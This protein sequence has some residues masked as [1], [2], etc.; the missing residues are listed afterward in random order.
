MVSVAS[1]GVR[2]S[3]PDVRRIV[4]VVLGAVLAILTLPLVIATAI[5]AAVALRTWPFFV[6]ERV[7]LGGRTFRFVKLRTLP[8]AAPKYLDKYSLQTMEIPRICRW[9]RAMH[10]DE[11][12]QLWLV[13][14]GR[15]SLVGPRPEMAFLHAQLEPGFARRRTS[16]RPGCTGLW[17]VSTH[18]HNMIFEHPEFDEYYLQHRTFGLDM[19]ILGRTFGLM[20]PGRNRR[21]VSLSAFDERVQPTPIPVSMPTPLVANVR[22]ERQLEPVEA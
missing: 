9:L 22:A 7:G 21:L 20:L 4:D 12:P 13:V 19:W 10:L 16:V 14:T 3:V 1:A 17:Q 6:Q 8:S 11:L 5:A 2:G 15:M 18:C